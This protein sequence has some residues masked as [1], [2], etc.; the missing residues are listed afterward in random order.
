MSSKLDT[1]L[2]DILKTRRTS[3]RRGGARGGRRSD[4]ARPAPTGPVGG[5]SKSTRPPKQPKSAGSGAPVQETS[6]KILVSGLPHD[7]DQTQLQLETDV[8]ATRY[9]YNRGD[10]NAPVSYDWHRMNRTIFESRLLLYMGMGNALSDLVRSFDCTATRQRDAAAL[11]SPPSRCC[12][13]DYFATAVGVGRPKKV[14]LQYGPTGRSLGSAT[15]IFSKHEQAV[16]ATSA[17]NGVKI[18][19]RPVRVEMLVSA[20]NLPATSTASSLADRV[21]NPKKD[22]PKPATAAKAAPATAGR[23][24]GARE[25]RGRGRGGRD[26]R[27]GRERNKKKTVEELDA[28]MADYFP[29]TEGGNDTIIATGTDGAQA[30]AGGDTAMDDEML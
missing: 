25:A 22:K 12:T 21:T 13:V 6:G 19:N 10:C 29:A 15:I 7:I 24:R 27:G 2:D 18:D 1:S 30:T 16:K 11:C 5:V 20:A 26:A 4:A 3:T 17:L 28:E 23:G 14:L 9:T 8:H